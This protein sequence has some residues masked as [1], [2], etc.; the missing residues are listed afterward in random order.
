M[1]GELVQWLKF[2]MIM[3]FILTVVNL[4]QLGKLENIR[5]QLKNIMKHYDIKDDH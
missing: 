4:V 1:T 2:T 3:V 5:E